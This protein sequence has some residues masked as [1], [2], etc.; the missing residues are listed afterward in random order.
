MNCK[1]LL[2]LVLVCTF[3]ASAHA[4][5]GKG[6]IWLGGSIGFSQS[7]SDIGSNQK[8]ES[9][10]VSPAVGKAIKENLIAG[11]RLGYSKSTS[12]NTNSPES[13][14]NS[15]TENYGGG[16]FIRR[17]VPVVNR[18]YIFG[19]GT[20]SYAASKQTRDE[21]YSNIKVSTENKGWS[22]SLSFTPGVSYGISKK[23]QLETGFNSLFSMSYG[24][25]KLKYLN[26]PSG[27]KQTSEGFSAGISLENASTFYIGFRV[28]LNNKG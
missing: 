7:K 24:K 20:A 1:F 23:F 19:E 25:S 5:I 11:V 2:S 10:N 27:T 4:Q 3:I 26:A 17:Y 16:I 9:F 13:Y 12:K 6:S 28:L 22:T 8:M 15:T 18:L 21:L 14:F